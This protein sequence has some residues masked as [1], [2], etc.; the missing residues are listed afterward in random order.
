MADPRA[1]TLSH[2]LRIVD[3][4]RPRLLLVENVPGFARHG[5]LAFLEEQLREINSRRRTRYS[6]TSTTLN[7]ADYGVPQLRKRLV[8]I[9]DRDGRQFN[10]PQSTHGFPGSE[11]WLTTWDAIGDLQGRDFEEDLRPKG[12]WAN[13]L[14]SIPEGQNYLWHTER[15]GGRPIFGWRTRYWSF[16][17]KLAKSKP[18]WTIAASP[19]QNHGP[20]HWK[21]RRLSTEELR[22]LQTFP[23]SA[24]IC[25]SFT[26]R[27]RQLGNA[28]P[29]L[30]AEVL[31]I[32]IARHFGMVSR[33][34]PRLG[35]SPAVAFPGPE[36]PATVP[37][38]YAELI[39]DHVAH[40]GHGKGPGAA[41]RAAAKNPA[42]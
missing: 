38:E 42:P 18:A 32:E 13:L 7:A 25:G 26:S 8:A 33:R 29:S 27:Q 5:G 3:E 20:F 28:V 10:F 2:L 17:L 23:R 36:R 22:C 15:G 6:V 4:I 39:G 21:N 24:T 40:P 14:P 1:G 19:S 16:L 9:A 41:R 37:R 12:R 31:G 11:R 34:R 30:L 35:I